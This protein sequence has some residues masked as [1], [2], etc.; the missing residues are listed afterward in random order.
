MSPCPTEVRAPQKSVSHRSPCPT[1]VRAPQK[2]V[3]H[4]SPCPTAVHSLSRLD[5]FQLDPLKQDKSLGCINNWCGESTRCSDQCCSALQ[6]S[7]QGR[8]LSL[9]K[10]YCDVP[11]TSMQQQATQ[12]CVRCTCIEICVSRVLKHTLSAFQHRELSRRAMTIRPDLTWLSN[13]NPCV[14]GL[15]K[16]RSPARCTGTIHD[17]VRPELANNMMCP[18]K[19][20]SEISLIQMS[21]PKT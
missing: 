21:D 20:I 2:S 6:C 17:A 4:M 16:C 13:S 5:S 9:L 1:E 18:G 15:R 8:S 11:F 3:P 12:D 10:I 7:F 19:Y 14:C